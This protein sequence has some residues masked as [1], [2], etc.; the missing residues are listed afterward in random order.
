MGIKPLGPNTLP[1]LESFTIIPDVQINF[2][3]FKLPSL[4]F[5]T[6]QLPKQSKKQLI[7]FFSE[8]N[9]PISIESIYLRDS[10][11]KELHKACEFAC[12]N[13]S[14]IHQ[15]PFQINEKDLFEAIQSYQPLP[16][17]S[18]IIIKNN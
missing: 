8:L 18:K 10:T 16:K 11:S 13:N 1:S 15:L 2:S 5:S 14:D 9:L 17:T 12:K 6:S 3:K 4:I 7:N